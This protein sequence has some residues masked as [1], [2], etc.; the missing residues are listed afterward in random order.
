MLCVLKGTPIKL[1][2][3][4]SLNSIAGLSC[5]VFC[6][7]VEERRAKKADPWLQ[8][9]EMTLLFST[10]RKPCGPTAC[11]L[12]SWNLYLVQIVDH[13]YQCLRRFVLCLSIAVGT[14]IPKI[15]DIFDF[16]CDI[17]FV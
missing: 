11:S 17:F 13:A 3:A 5:L 14:S 15:F 7:V 6:V 2:L 1:R 12:L 4:S 8:M 16:M 9:I 10:L